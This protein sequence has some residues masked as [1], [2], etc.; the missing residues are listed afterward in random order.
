LD[1]LKKRARADLLAQTGAHHSQFCFVRFSRI[2]GRA[3]LDDGGRSCVAVLYENNLF[4]SNVHEFLALKPR[5]IDPPSPKRP[6]VTSEGEGLVSHNVKF[7]YLNSDR[8]VLNGINAR[9]ACRLVGENGS[10]KTTLVKLLTWLY[11]PTDGFI[12]MDGVDLREL[13]L[14]DLRRKISVVFQRLSRSTTFQRRRTSGS[15]TSKFRRT[16]SAS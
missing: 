13:S 9:R 6:A 16:N 5:V 14:G 4:L 11:D 3:R 10:G 1:L 2:P 7:R 15:A 8:W 12:T